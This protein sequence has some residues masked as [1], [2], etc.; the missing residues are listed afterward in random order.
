MANRR[1][2]E[3][4]WKI[5]G[6]E[7]GLMGSKTTPRGRKARATQGGRQGMAGVKN[8]LFAAARAARSLGL[9]VRSSKD[10]QGNISSCYI[11]DGQY[12]LRISDHQIPIARARED[13][14]GWHEAEVIVERPVSHDVWHRYL[15][16]KFADM[17]R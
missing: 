8:T 12:M 1:Q 2:K 5:I 6:R 7:G 17:R 10:R 3:K 11:T 9:K 16:M 15:R 4:Q 14:G 13:G